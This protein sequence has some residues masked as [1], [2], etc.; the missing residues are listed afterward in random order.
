VKTDR[1][2][3]SKPNLNLHRLTDEKPAVNRPK[4]PVYHENEPV[5]AVF[6]GKNGKF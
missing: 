1:F 5:F 2:A 4:P 3:Q 6:T